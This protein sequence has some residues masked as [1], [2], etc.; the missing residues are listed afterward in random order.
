MKKKIQ[1]E[2]TLAVQRY[3]A[4]E[5]PEGICASFGRTKRWLYK[6][7]SRHTSDDPAWFE[8]QSRRPISSPNRTPAE[9]EKIEEKHWGQT[10]T[11]DK[12]I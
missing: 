2:R 9:I 4:G 3:F 1:K 5:D 8:D 6:W 12:F 10:Y 11:F 7:V